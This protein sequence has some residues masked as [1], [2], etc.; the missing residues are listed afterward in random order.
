[1]AG[2]GRPADRAD[3]RE[4]PPF[5]M[6][7]RGLPAFVADFFSVYAGIPLSTPI[8]LVQNL[9]FGAVDYACGPDFEPHRDFRAAA[10]RL[11]T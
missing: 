6:D 7:Q 3:D 11:E 9:V 4:L 10:L 1:M 2:E 5:A 8:E